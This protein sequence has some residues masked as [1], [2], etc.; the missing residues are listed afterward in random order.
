MVHRRRGRPTYYLKLPTRTGWIQRSTGTSDRATA[1][2]IARMLEDLGPQGRRAWDLL[3]AVAEDRLSP[4]EL[5]D[6]WSMNDL[7]GLRARLADQDLAG[8]IPAWRTWLADRVK[9]GTADLYVVHLRTLMPEGVLY[10][11][12]NFTGP[13]V[14]RW[15][16]ARTTLAQKRKPGSTKSKRKDDRET[17]PA[18]ASTKR[19]YFAAVQ[20]FVQ[21]LIETGALTESPVRDVSPPPASEPRCQFLELPD[22]KRLVDGADLPYRAI[23]ALA[24][25]AGLEI[26][27]ILS[28]V[29]TDV[30]RET[31]QVRARGTKAWTRDRL[32]RV[33]DWAW[34]FVEKHLDTLTPGERVFRGTNRWGASEYHRERLKT[35]G[36]E[37]YRLHDARHHWA[38]RMARAGAPFELIAR[39]LG[40]RDV[41]MVAK[42]YGRFKPDTEERD[43]WE[44][45]AAARDVEKFERRGATGGAKT[46]DERVAEKDESLASPWETEAS[47]R[48]GGENRTHDPLITRKGEAQAH[49]VFSL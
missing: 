41:A 33:A 46:G 6:A 22:V 35:L 5:Y 21:Y 38:V 29:E 3:D 31:R 24:Y 27:A 17:R 26:S 30:D 12:S 10:L 13:A 2:A 1:K 43:R 7:D 48:A 42:V 9:A 28:L 11:R 47:D 18:S 32:A 8:H 20:S 14:A 15:L 16:S 19:R 23:F 49:L 25:G 36:L 40:H 4:G 34:L 44:R 39:Q 37:G 45:I